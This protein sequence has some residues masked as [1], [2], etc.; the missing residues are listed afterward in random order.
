MQRPSNCSSP[1]YSMSSSSWANSVSDLMS[2]RQPVRRAARR[3]FWPSRPIAS[4]S[5]SSGTITVAWRSSSSTITS[6]TRAGES[7]LATK[8]AGSSLWGMMSIFSPRS[9]ETTI[10][11]REPRGPT[12]AP[13]GSTPSAWEIDGDLRA[14]A[15]LAGDADDLDQLVGDL[16]DLEFEQL[17][18]QLGAAAGDDDRR[19]FGRV[20]DVGDHRLD[21]HP[22]VV[23][24]VV[25]LLGLGQQRLDPLAQLDQRVALVGLLDD[26]GDQLADPVLV[27]VEH[28][29]PFG[30]ADPLQDHLL[31]GLG[32]DP[33][34]VFGGDVAGRDL[35]LVGGDHLRVELGV[36]GLAQLARSPGRPRAP[37]PPGP[38]PPRRAASPPARAAGSVRRRGS[39]RSRG[40]GRRGRIWRRRGSSCR[41]RAA[42]RR[43]R[44]SACRRRSPSPAR[45]P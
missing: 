10:R 20:G 38:R 7:A 9:S 15:G 30:L 25:D 13:T 27:L 37:P 3:A 31:G 11:T 23:A 35:V 17:L 6:R 33:A 22:V 26:P 21:P 43:A 32:G 12:Q 28:H 1:S 36:L 29:H 8:R 16:G 44:P 34:E 24:L 45:A 18:D 40:R 19:A 39:R 42:R 2:T 41:R 14:V 4:E 5:W